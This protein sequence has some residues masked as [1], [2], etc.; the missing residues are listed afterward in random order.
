MEPPSLPAAAA[1]AAFVRRG[2]D[3]GA[4]VQACQ[5]AFVV[6]GGRSVLFVLVRHTRKAC[7]SEGV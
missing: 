7:V 4:G 1:A 2:A 5:G 6:A 3:D